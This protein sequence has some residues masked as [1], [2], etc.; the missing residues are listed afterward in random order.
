MYQ[1]SLLGTE[2]QDEIN[3]GFNQVLDIM[4]DPVVQMCI[5][6]SEEKM[7]A[8]PRWDGQVF[9]LN[10][11]CY[12]QVPS[13]PFLLGMS[14]TAILQSVL[15]AFEFTT[16]KQ[17]GIQKII[18]KQ[19]NLLTDEHSDNVL[20]DAGLWEVVE[21]CETRSSD[22]GHFINHPKTNG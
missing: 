6:N 5:T 18:N 20:R 21:T 9:I 1:S 22:V 2:D 15:S 8:R 11:L 3:A 10:C 13:F 14:L 12:L 17:T 19:I 16:Q 7:K 4:I